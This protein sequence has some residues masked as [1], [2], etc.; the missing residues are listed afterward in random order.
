MTVSAA[1][2]IRPDGPTVGRGPAWPGDVPAGAVLSAEQLR[3]LIGD[4]LFRVFEDPA[5]EPSA[6][7]FRAALDALEAALAEQ[8]TLGEVRHLL[9]DI[10]TE[11]NAAR[12]VFTG[13]HHF[14]LGLELG[15]RLQSAFSQGG[16]FEGACDARSIAAVSARL[17]IT[18]DLE[19]DA[20]LATRDS[21]VDTRTAVLQARSERKK[22]AFRLGGERLGRA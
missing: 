5:C 10:Q 16:S 1:S 15:A 6:K 20:Y 22:S 8:G 4:N 9:L 2:H 3:C 21:L 11:M 18:A 12:F 7:A 14:R 13:E 17:A 19:Q